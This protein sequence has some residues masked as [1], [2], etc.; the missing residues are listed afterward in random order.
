MAEQNKI[1]VLAIGGNA[2]IPAGK[3]GTIDEQREIT[4]RSMEQVTEMICRGYRVVMTHGN[5]PIVG[6]ILIRNE[7]AKSIVPPMPLDICGADSEGGI[8]YMLQQSLKNSFQKKGLDL[9]AVTLI[10]QVLVNPE[11]EAFKHPTKPI[12]PFYNAFE[13][14]L[15]EDE[16]GWNMIEDSGRGYR[17]VVPSPYP[18]DIIEKDVI[19]LLVTSGVIVIAG[20]GGGVPVAR[21]ADGSL[22]GVEAVIDKDRVAGLLAQLIGANELILI[23]STPQVA[24]DFGKPTQR[25]LHHTNLNELLQLQ[26]Q[27]QF[28]PGS[29]GPK[30]ESIIQFL[31]NGGQRAIITCPG[32]VRRGTQG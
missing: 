19:R 6:N 16:K 22:Y 21:K 29:M 8:G 18:L 15:M 4:A 5:G 9:S 1:A 7:A 17:R 10:T 11:D 28:P 2:I 12:G 20:G 14:E 27:N 30:I 31:H 24:V 32:P 23:T 13:A 25:L 3:C 26:A